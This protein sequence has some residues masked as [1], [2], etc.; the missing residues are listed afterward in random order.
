[1]IGHQGADRVDHPGGVN[2]AD[3]EHL[4]TALAALAFSWW[5]RRGHENGARPTDAEQRSCLAGDQAADEGQ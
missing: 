1:V 2:E 3:L 4:A 5:R